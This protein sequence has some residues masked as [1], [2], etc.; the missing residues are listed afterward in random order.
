MKTLR[1]LAA[2]VLNATLTPLVAL[3]LVFEEWGWEPL[4]RWLARL[5]RLPLWARLELAVASLPPWLALA[6]FAAPALALF[7]LKLLALYWMAQGHVV[8]GVLVIALAKI[9]GTAMVARLFQLTQPSLMRLAWFA[10]L[11]LRWKT[12]KDALLAR[13]RA[14][15][16]WRMARWGKRQA[17]HRARR[18]W[19]ALRGQGG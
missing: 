16:P 13:L 15:R 5:N 19:R 9:A 14:S 8:L 2:S 12:F 11:Y 17:S 18:L 1:R 7:P 3:L 6:T 10:R 4:A